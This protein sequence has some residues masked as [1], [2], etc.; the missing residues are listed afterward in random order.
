MQLAREIQ[1][2]AFRRKGRF[3]VVMEGI[4]VHL[5]TI[6]A[7]LIGAASDGPESLKNH[8]G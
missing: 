7:A 5:I 4:S 8:N 3:K 1:A 2:Y 6:R